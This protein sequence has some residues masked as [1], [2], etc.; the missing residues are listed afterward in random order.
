M[1]FKNNSKHWWCKPKDFSQ[2]SLIHKKNLNWMFHR[3]KRLG[4]AHALKFWIIYT[5]KINSSDF[6]PFPTPWFPNPHKNQKALICLSNFLAAFLH[7]SENQQHS[8]ATLSYIPYYDFFFW[9]IFVH[10]WWT[11]QYYKKYQILRFLFLTIWV[12]GYLYIPV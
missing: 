2:V 3:Y 11:P 6:P 5:N 10:F 9:L 4:R 1:N 7:K 12:K 8:N